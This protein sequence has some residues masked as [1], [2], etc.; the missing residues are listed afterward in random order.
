MNKIKQL[1]ALFLLASASMFGQNQIPVSAEPVTQPA[2]SVDFQGSQV[3]SVR[4][5]AETMPSFVGGDEAM[6]KYLADNIKYPQTAKKGK[7]EGV[8]YASFVVDKEGNMTNIA[9]KKGLHPECD[10]EVLRVLGKMPKWNPGKDATGQLVPVQM[11][12]PVKFKLD[13][14]DSKPIA[15]PTQKKK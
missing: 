14:K 8:V 2:N 4:A 1:L 3:S 13:T 5:S 9:I 6:I 15:A 11:T 12:L 10:T 7:V